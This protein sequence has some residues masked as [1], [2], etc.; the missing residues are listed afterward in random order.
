M[1]VSKKF[2]RV[3]R[4]IESAINFAYFGDHY[5]IIEYKDKIDNYKTTRATRTGLICGDDVIWD[6]WEDPY[7]DMDKV[8]SVYRIRTDKKIDNAYQGII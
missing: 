6:P 4:D 3:F 5:L 7:I 1:F 2:S 8:R